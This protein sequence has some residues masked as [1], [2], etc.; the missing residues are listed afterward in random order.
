M[1]SSLDREVERC[2]F[3]S[4]DDG[5]GSEPLLFHGAVNVIIWGLKKGGK[6]V[7]EWKE[8]KLENL[9][10]DERLAKSIRMFL[11]ENAKLVAVAAKANVF[12][13]L[14]GLIVKSIEDTQSM[15]EEIT[16]ALTAEVWEIEENNMASRLEYALHRFY[17]EAPGMPD[18]QGRRSVRDEVCNTLGELIST[19]K[20]HLL[21]KD[22]WEAVH[23]R[24]FNIFLIAVTQRILVLGFL[25]QDS[26]SQRLDMGGLHQV[27]NTYL[28]HVNAV[29]DKVCALRGESIHVA[30]T[31]RKKSEMGRSHGKHGWEL[32][33]LSTSSRMRFVD[34]AEEVAQAARTDYLQFI[35]TKRVGAVIALLEEL[36]RTTTT[37]TSQVKCMTAWASGWGCFLS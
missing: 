18:K 10:T 13:W 17:V 4:M 15:A 14:C 32:V 8:N 34:D 12:V 28:K 23:W 25:Q 9:E 37:T 21:C 22:K 36:Q 31:R 35:K 7:D 2:D 29:G 30:G 5:N 16:K 26:T 3:A 27:A 6:I 20:T 33:D 1:S 24:M 19:A 11:S